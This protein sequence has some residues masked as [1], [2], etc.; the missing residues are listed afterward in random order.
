M[1]ATEEPPKAPHRMLMATESRPFA[2]T[3]VE[4]TPTPLLRP[5]IFA[6][7]SCCMDLPTFAPPAPPPPVRT[8]SMSTVYLR[9]ILEMCTRSCACV[10]SLMAGTCLVTIFRLSTRFGVRPPR[11]VRS[12]SWSSTNL[13]TD[14]EELTTMP[15]DCRASA[16][17]GSLNPSQITAITSSVMLELRSWFAMLRHRL[18]S[19]V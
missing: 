10:F 16:Q 3:A 12:I 5:D 1:R 14:T 7:R 15:R 13:R 8:S 17:K 9:S 11:K 6:R 4:V 2:G 18:P 19:E